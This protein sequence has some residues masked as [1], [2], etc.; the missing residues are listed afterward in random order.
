MKYCKHCGEKIEEGQKFC[1]KCGTKIVAAEAAATAVHS[2]EKKPSKRKLLTKNKLWIIVGVIA[3]SALGAITWGILAEYDSSY[4][5]EAFVAPVA[6]NNAQSVVD[7][8]CDNGEGG[9]GTIFT[10]TGTILTNNHV[11]TGSTSCKVTIPN[12]ATGQISEIYEAAPVIV[13][14][15]SKKYDVATV[16]IDASYTDSDGKT[17]GAY[18]TTFTPFTLPSTCSTSTA[19]K[20]GDSIRI[21]GYPVTSGGY[22]LTETD[23]IISSFADNGDIL[24]SAKVDSGNSGGLAID[25][26]GCY[27]GIP[28]AVIS[29]NY[30]NL[31]VII[32]GNVVE[33]FI[34]NVPVKKDLVMEGSASK[35]EAIQE[36]IT[37]QVADPV[38][39]PASGSTAP[40]ETPTQ[41]CQATYGAYSQTVGDNAS[42]EPLCN[43]DSGYAWGGDGNSCVAKTDLLA[44]C[45]EQFGVGSFSEVSNGKSVCGCSTGYE[46]NSDDTACVAPQPTCTD[47][48]TYD[49]STD[50]CECD[51]GY[52]PDGSICE[53]GLEYCQDTD[54][55]GATYDSSSNSCACQTGYFSYNNTCESGYSY[56]TDKYGANYEYD[57]STNGCTASSY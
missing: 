27:L 46:M 23:G 49:T 26:N 12:P 19:S 53:S 35:D 37:P 28:S 39:P 56:C 40:S 5:S 44:Y 43:C 3:L 11:I 15:L 24:T 52:T 47:N 4:H 41:Q 29:G 2:H 51:T 1:K 13:S 7:I 38:T 31:G 6:T 25:Q 8:L 33:Q 42:G 48:A 57:S 18:P 17:W 22:N 10:T 36:D 45:Q 50:K 32:P 21:Y 55:Y 34:P 9:S 30:Q 16:Q 14:V 54:G 20:L